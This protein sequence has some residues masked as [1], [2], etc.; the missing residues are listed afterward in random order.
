MSFTIVALL[1]SWTARAQQPDSSAQD[2]ISDFQKLMPSAGALAQNLKPSAPNPFQRPGSNAQQAANKSAD[3]GLLQLDR[4]WTSALV[5]YAFTAPPGF[6]SSAHNPSETSDWESSLS[7]AMTAYINPSYTTYARMTGDFETYGQKREAG[8]AGQP[9][10]QSFTMEWELAH[11]VTSRL[12]SLEIAAGSY[13]QQLV[14]YP[15]FANS[16]LQDA[17]LGYSGSATGF[18]TSFT[19]PDKNLTFSL[20]YGKEHSY[21]APERTHEARFEFS[22]TW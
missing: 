9:G 15:A 8:E 17:F 6:Y 19:L 13:R 12:G 10:G 16:P 22:W 7:G 18:E 14:S 21:A 3:P 20:R 4:A 1:A 5:Q 2:G 11:L